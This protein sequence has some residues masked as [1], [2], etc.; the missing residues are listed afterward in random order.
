MYYQRK[1]DLML[2]DRKELENNLIEVMQVS[3][4]KAKRKIVDDIKNELRRYKV[5]NAQTW[6]NEPE[7]EIPNLDRRELFLLTEQVF[8]KT[9]NTNIAPDNYFTEPEQKKS[10]QYVGTQELEEDIVLP[11][12]LK[13]FE[14]LS[15]NEFS[16]T[17]DANLVAKLSMSRLLH[18]NF[19]IQREATKRK[20]K[21]VVITEAK[22]VMQ[23]VIEIKDHLKKNTLK[24]TQLV[25]NASVGSADYGEPEIIYDEQERTITITKGT[26]LDIVDGYH[27]TKGTEMA[28]H[29]QG[30]LDFKF[31]LLL[32]NYS[33]DEARSFQ[34]Q[35]AKATPIAKER[36]EELLG[37]RMAD[38]VLKEVIPKTELQG[39]VSSNRHVHTS[40]DE[41]VAYKV[42][43]ETIER[44]FKLEKMVDVYKA[45]NYLT[46]VFNYI[47]GTFEDEFLTSPKK[48][49]EKS[50]LNDNNMFSGFITLARKLMELK[51]DPSEII[52][53]I[54]SIDF[55]KS[56]PLWNE[57]GV[58]DKKGNLT[59]KARDSI[60]N[61]FENI[62]INGYKEKV[63]K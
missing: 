11:L 29:E 40:D 18:Y 58:L 57:I 5:I 15:I 39:R 33:D 16:G 14:R 27:R 61:Y 34:G 54:S 36:A 53:I 17:I 43:A 2:R 48:Y 46:K 23:N 19:D 20:V 25:F 10:R 51:I 47:L 35:I 24:P 55:D 60:I 37:E 52:G 44:Q 9:A 59:P 12:T 56:N 63:N 50:L 3:Q 26:I 7:T 6:I 38:A 42:L 21:D 28:F 30:H 13:N 22:L 49:R 41:L 62:E 8:L 31:T 45:A 1:V 4:L 32:T